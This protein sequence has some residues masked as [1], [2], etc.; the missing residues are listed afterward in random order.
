[1]SVTTLGGEM[2]LPVMLDVIE[3]GRRSGA[4][5]RGERDDSHSRH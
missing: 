3:V 2:D 4:V 5:T 1:M